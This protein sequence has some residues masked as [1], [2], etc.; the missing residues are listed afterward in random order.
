VK[1]GK[2]QI[3]GFI[4]R[5]HKVRNTWKHDVKWWQLL[6]ATETTFD[7][8]VKGFHVYQDEF[9][10]AAQTAFFFCVGAGYKRK[11]SGLGS[12]TKTNGHRCEVKYSLTNSSFRLERWLPCAQYSVF[13][14]F[15]SSFRIERCFMQNTE[16]FNAHQIFVGLIYL[17]K[18]QKFFAT[19]I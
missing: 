16:L 5:G 7:S 6:E 2:H 11:K 13:I 4:A 3:Y 18:L 1:N 10:L 17:W 15:L 12:E 14:K 8:C 9:S 19:Q